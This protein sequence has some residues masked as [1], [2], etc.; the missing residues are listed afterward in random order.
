MWAC[1]PWCEAPASHCVRRTL[2]RV[3]ARCEETTV[4]AP[5][6]LARRIFRPE[7]KRSTARAP[8]SEPVPAHTGRPR[9]DE[10]MVVSC[11]LRW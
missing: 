8:V 7:R 11:W 2:L 10:E 3:A 6:S 9:R 4:L 5:H 1:S